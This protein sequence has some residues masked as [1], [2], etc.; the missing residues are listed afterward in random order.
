MTLT[1][2][3]IAGEETFCT[4]VCPLGHLFHLENRYQLLS[5]VSNNQIIPQSFLYID[6]DETTTATPT[7][8]NRAYPFHGTI[9]YMFSSPLHPLALSFIAP[10]NEHVALLIGATILH[11][12]LL[13]SGNLV[14]V[15][16]LPVLPLLCQRHRV[17]DGSREAG[18]LD[19]KTIERTLNLLIIRSSSRSW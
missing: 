3:R 17:A 1:N 6:I 13:Y 9:A 18:W 19:R 4:L 8:T 2:R 12:W 10:W 15:A 16:V 11:R 5:N 7:T 14:A